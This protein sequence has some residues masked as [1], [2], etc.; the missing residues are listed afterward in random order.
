V[1]DDFCDDGNDDTV[2]TCSE[3][4][5]TYECTNET[6]E[7]QI[8]TDYYPDETSWEL[9]QEGVTLG[10]GGGYTDALTL[11]THHVC[12][13]YGNVIFTI[14][15]SFGDGI[16]CGGGYVI[17]HKGVEKAS[18]GEF[19]FS[20]SVSF[21]IDL[22]C[23]VDSDCDDG[24]PDSINTCQGGTCTTVCVTDDFC[25][26]GNDD[27]VDT[28]SEGECTYECTNETVEVQ[29]T[30][31]YY[32]DETSWE[33]VQEGVTLGEGGGYTDALTLHTHHVCAGYGNV[34]FTIFDS[35]GDGICC[36]EEGQGGYVI[37]HDGV[38]KASGGVFGFSESVSFDITHPIPPT[39][40]CS[41][42]ATASN[43][44]P[45][46]DVE[47]CC[48]WDDGDVP[49]IDPGKK[50]TPVS[51]SLHGSPSNSTS[52]DDYDAWCQAYVEQVLS[53]VACALSIPSSYVALGRKWLKRCR[54]E[55]RE[56]GIVVPLILRRNPWEGHTHTC[57]RL[58]GQYAAEGSPLWR[59]NLTKEMRLDYPPCNISESSAALEMADVGGDD[60]G[61]IFG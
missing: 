53:D 57:H 14:F 6:V 9:V 19:G 7:V 34:I 24:N 5:C 15:D 43:Y 1:T 8:T 42:D 10:E 13:G 52:R 36:S 28:C 38:E 50:G 17:T 18:G 39:I 22:P 48:E 40:G 56:G 30:T 61:D 41:T 47:V 21:D 32:P 55:W 44:R 29:I 16:C 23:N 27:T 58:N 45:N 60:E 51:I 59:G 20:E 49:A 37:T 35:Y 11:H 2:D 33:L 3:G 46:S 25:D 31:D 12:A 4:E 54:K 26:D